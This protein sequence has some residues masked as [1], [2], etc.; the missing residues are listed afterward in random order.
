MSG[1][2]KEKFDGIIREN[3]IKSG[4]SEDSF[5][6][7]KYKNYYSDEEFGKFKSEMK[8]EHLKKYAKGSGGELGKDDDTEAKEP[9][10]M[11]SVG[12]SSR[13]CYLALRDVAGVDFEKSCK[14]AGIRGNAPQLDAYIPQDDCDVFVEAKCHEIFDKNK[15]EMSTQYLDYFKNNDIFGDIASNA[16]IK[17]KEFSAPLKIFGIDK[18]SSMLD[19]KQLLCHLMGIASNMGEKPA[20]LVYM[21]FI[22]ETKDEKY[23]EKIKE[24][25][26]EL[27]NEIHAVF[28]SKPI[29]DF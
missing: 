4:V 12:S 15:I 25:F 20:K 28:T 1:I 23:T 29:A 10:K 26:N 5:R 19:I 24:V 2:T 17:G 6:S 9:P 7:D 11:A 13:F 18:E 21:F 16:T 22:P 27:R 3:L 14:I 8:E